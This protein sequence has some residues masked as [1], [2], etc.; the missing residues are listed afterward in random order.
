MNKA[1]KEALTKQYMT[2][3]IPQITDFQK[4]WI[5]KESAHY[6]F[7]DR[8]DNGN[9]ICHCD[10]CGNTIDLGKTKHRAKVKCPS[11]GAELEIIH[12]WR[13]KKLFSIETVDWFVIPKAV[14]S[15]TLMLRY[16]SAW[17]NGLNSNIS[18]VARIVF[19]TRMKSVHYFEY[20]YI[21]DGKWGWKYSRVHYFTEFNMY[22][23]RTL[24]CLPAKLYKPT[25]LRELRRLDCFK[26][27]PDFMYYARQFHY[28]NDGLKFIGY[29]APLYEKLIKAGFSEYVKNDF[30]ETTSLRAMTEH[31]T[32]ENSL[33]KMLGLNKVQFRVFRDNQTN[34]ALRFIKI[35]P[36]ITQEY[37][38][39]LMASRIRAKDVAEMK[40]EG[41]NVDKTI[42]YVTKQSCSFYEWKHYVELLKK[43]NYNMDESYLYPRDFRKEDQRVSAEYQEKLRIEREKADEERRKKLEEKEREQNS[44]I[45]KISEGLRNNPE[46]REFFAGSDGLQIMVPDSINDFKEEGRNLHNCLG[47]YVD[48]YANGKTLIFFVRRIDDPTAPY[49]AMEYCHGEVVQCREDYNRQANDK[50]VDFAE[51]LANKLR[52]LNILAA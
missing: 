31:N 12:K 4:E 9:H 45:A 7:V 18:E 13:I 8:D 50:V 48:R 26:Y 46:I 23:F 2:S 11:C 52:K 47:T 29:K 14:D 25:W 39:M 16:V 37:L 1:K 17:R 3:K 15:N 27:F 19:D 41:I 40:K 20:S 5:R 35:F 32:K 44:L 49:V 10:K 30:K 22:N 34:S 33:I 28:I 36:N 43:L 42:K 51:A 6:I 24:C 38:D 21:S